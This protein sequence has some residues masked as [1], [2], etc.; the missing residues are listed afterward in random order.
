MPRLR[1]IDRALR[2]HRLLAAGAGILIALGAVALNAHAAL[3]E[4]H[5]H[6]GE[7][8]I[9]V[10]ALSIA[11]ATGALWLARREPGP[12]GVPLRAGAPRRIEL[13]GVTREAPRGPR[14]RAGPALGLT[15]LR[16]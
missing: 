12:A 13:R 2:R 14:S 5:H 6:H 16:R 9:C 8:T 11:V 4:H 3:P 7:E 10:A 1:S 15:V